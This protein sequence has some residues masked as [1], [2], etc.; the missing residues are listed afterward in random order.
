MVEG[1]KAVPSV[2]RDEVGV[3]SWKRRNSKNMFSCLMVSRILESR[4][5]ESPE[6]HLNS[7]AK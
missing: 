3:E 2:E 6:M 1:K 4:S 7:R 5:D